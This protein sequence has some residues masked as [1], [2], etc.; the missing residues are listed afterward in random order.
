MRHDFTNRRRAILGTLTLLIL[1]DVA[2]AAYSLELASTPNASDAQ[3][4][5]RSLDLK[6][7]EAQIKRAQEIREGMPN[8]QKEYEKFEASF[9]PASSG[10]SSISSELGEISKKSGARLDELTFKPTAIPD[11]GMT[12]VA[13]DSIIA[14]DYKSVIQF[15][16]GLQRSPNNFVVE[17]LTL[18][19]EGPSQGSANMI[20]VGLHIK[21]YLRTSA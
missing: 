3:L 5:Q 14:G 6:R 4:R 15:L 12:E 20:K 19:T 17:S 2:L 18:A 13:I 16:N 9:L 10:Y 7:I 8:N 1:A 21:T 11:R